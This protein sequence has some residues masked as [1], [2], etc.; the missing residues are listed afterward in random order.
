MEAIEGD[1]KERSR[2]KRDE[3]GKDDRILGTNIS[4]NLLKNIEDVPFPKVP[5]TPNNQFFLMDVW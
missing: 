1:H 4:S 5:G 3:P 2:K